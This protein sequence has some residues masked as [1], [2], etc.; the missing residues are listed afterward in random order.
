MSDPITPLTPAQ[1]KAQE[2]QAAAEG[3]LRRD[4]VA[5]DIAANVVVLKGQEDE[6]ISSHAARADEQGKWWGRT[7]SRV[8]NFF[9]PDHGAKAQAGD[10]ERAENVQRLEEQSGGIANPNQPG[11]K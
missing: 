5:V 2:Q 3:W 11:D 9:Q 6:T 7:L 10:V 4:E 8:L 1:T